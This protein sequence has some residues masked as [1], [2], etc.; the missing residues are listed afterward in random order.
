MKKYFI[1]GVLI[2]FMFGI[3]FS[4]TYSAAISV[5][6][7]DIS[8]LKPG[9]EIVIS[10]RLDEKS[11]GL[12][13]GFQFFIEY[14]HSIISWNGTWDSPLT[15]VKSFYR[16]MPYESDSWLFNDTGNQIAASWTDPNNK[17]VEM[18]N[19]DI[20]FE[21]V[22][23]YMGG[24]ERGKNSRLVWGETFEQKNGVV[25]RGVSEMYSEKLDY[26]VLTKQDGEI[27]N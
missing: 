20:F 8:K 22:F 1:S 14:D 24:L 21:F 2:F 11:G 26:F 19:G 7:I 6:T 3:A 4:Q 12:I 5:K 27:K 9:D 18:A 10:I 17:G 25:V 13:A 16:N 23:T 15:G